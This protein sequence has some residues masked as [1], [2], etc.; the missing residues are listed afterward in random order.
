MNRHYNIIRHQIY[1]DAY[2]YYG[3]GIKESSSLLK[4]LKLSKRIPGLEYTFWMRLCKYLRMV[5]GGGKIFYAVALKRYNKLTYKYGINIPFVTEIDEGFYIGHYGCIVVNQKVVIG[6]NCNISQGVTIGKSNRGKKQGCAVIGDNVY[7][8]PGAK[9]VGHVII[10]NN[11]A[12]GANAVVTHDVPD[13]AVV[14]GVPARIVS[15]DGSEGYV[16]KKV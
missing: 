9:I 1:L 16:N 12:I 10:G 8:G 2:R 7:I 3:D 4:L 13:N 14:A 5:K 11:V 15:M 6:K